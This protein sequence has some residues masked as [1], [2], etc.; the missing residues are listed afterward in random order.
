MNS[1]LIFP[2]RPVSFLPS[3]DLACLSQEIRASW[4][5]VEMTQKRQIATQASDK[6]VRTF[7]CVFDP[8]VQ[9]GDLFVHINT[10]L[11]AHHKIISPNSTSGLPGS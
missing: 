9:P 11:V 3:G 1:F 4:N 5:Q 6:L 10:G 2:N 8:C 7:Y